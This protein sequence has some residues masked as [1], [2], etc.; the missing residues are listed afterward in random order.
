M[1]NE[2]PLSLIGLDSEDRWPPTRHVVNSTHRVRKVSRVD[3]RMVV[4]PMALVTI[5]IAY[6]GTQTE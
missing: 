4:H 2:Y 6:D 5:A 1:G 3:G